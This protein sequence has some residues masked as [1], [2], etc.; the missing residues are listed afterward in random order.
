MDT[1]ARARARAARRTRSTWTSSS[2]R[3]L[4]AAISRLL[5][6]NGAYCTTDVAADADD[7]EEAALPF[8]IVAPEVFLLDGRLTRASDV[9]AFAMLQHEILLEGPAALFKLAERSA[10]GARLASGG[11]GLEIA[12]G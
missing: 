8:R 10:C 9:Y 4:Q 1:R 5:A 11:R 6:A 7:E 12:R 2:L 3:G